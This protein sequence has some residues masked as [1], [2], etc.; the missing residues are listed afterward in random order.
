MRR[1][2]ATVATAVVVATTAT[3][4]SGCGALDK[5][6]DCANTAVTVAESVEDLQRAVSGASEDP[7]QAKEALDAIDKN[8]GELE[9]KTDNADV[10]KAVGDLG[11][12]VDEA[13]ADIDAGRSPDVGPV[14]DAADELTKVCSPG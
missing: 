5:A 8:V 11:K 9:G 12:A 10:G 14:G 6:L 13:R 7:T 3:A 1:T 2:L 4:I